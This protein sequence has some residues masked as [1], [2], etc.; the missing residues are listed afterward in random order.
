MSSE[1]YKSAGSGNVALTEGQTDEV[2]L[3]H[4][5]STRGVSRAETGPL[6]ADLRLARSPAVPL[7]K[8][9]PWPR[10]ELHS[11]SC[12]RSRKQSTVRW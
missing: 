11:G 7:R 12:G 9:M 3:E 10:G 1:L 8:R 6:L 4:R 2:A 5:C